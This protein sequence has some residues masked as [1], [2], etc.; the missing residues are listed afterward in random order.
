MTQTVKKLLDAIESLGVDMV[1]IDGSEVKKPEKLKEIKMRLRGIAIEL[2]EI[3]AF[4]PDTIPDTDK[5][6]AI[7]IATELMNE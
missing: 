4:E 7:K 5:E 6:E 1:S 3:D 2:L